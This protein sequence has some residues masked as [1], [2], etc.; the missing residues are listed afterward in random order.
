MMNDVKNPIFSPNKTVAVVCYLFMT[1]LGGSLFATLIIAI[2]CGIDTTVSFQELL[3]A[4]TKTNIDE[5]EKHLLKP[6]AMVNAL[7][8]MMTYLCSLALV[9]FFMRNFI[10]EDAIQ[11]KKRYKKLC[12]FIPLAAGVTYALTFLVDWRIQS[13]IHQTS[14]N[15]NSIVTMIE[16]GG[17][18]YMFIAVVLCA[19]IVEELIYRKAIFEFLKKKHIAISYLVSI[20]LFTL[21]HMFSSQASIGDWFLMCIPYAFSGLLLCVVYHLSDKNIYASWF[22]HLVNNLIAFLL[23]II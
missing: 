10:M 8:N 13:L 11:L 15:Q 21:P 12:W 4:L 19:P 20:L 2:Y 3:S 14:A 23:I 16:H 1:L 6:Y 5:I 22:A 7:T 9:F 18:P 17:A